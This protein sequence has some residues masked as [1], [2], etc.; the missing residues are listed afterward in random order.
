MVVYKQAALLQSAPELPSSVREV[1]K[2]VF[3]DTLTSLAN[4]EKEY[5]GQFPSSAQSC[6]ALSETGSIHKR[7]RASMNQ[8]VAEVR[9]VLLRHFRA[10]DIKET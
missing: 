8:E 7:K 4:P 5:D 6:S 1:I 2:Q 3:P 10:V 9:Q